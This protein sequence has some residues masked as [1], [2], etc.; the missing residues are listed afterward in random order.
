MPK[1][2]VERAAELLSL[3]RKWGSGDPSLDSGLSRD[4]RLAA[5][6]MQGLL[7]ENERLRAELADAK[8][9]SDG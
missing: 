2:D 1:G 3:G 4:A 5:E 8:G 7:A 6:M 9:E